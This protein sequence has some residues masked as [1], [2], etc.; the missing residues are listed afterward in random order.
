MESFHINL[1]LKSSFIL[2]QYT[3]WLYKLHSLQNNLPLLTYVQKILKVLSRNII[4]HTKHLQ[5]YVT[6][7]LFDKIKMSLPASVIWLV[8]PMGQAFQRQRNKDKPHHA[9]W[10]LF[11][12]LLFLP[13]F[14]ITVMRS[15]Y[16]QYSCPHVPCYYN[17]TASSLARM[18]PL[19]FAT[20][21]PLWRS[22]TFICLKSYNIPKPAIWED[23]ITQVVNKLYT[24]RE[25]KS[26]HSD[27]I[28]KELYFTASSTSQQTWP[29]MKLL[30]TFFRQ[31]L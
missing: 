10:F 22:F 9:P 16:K 8:S 4:K 25:I 21:P 29:T 13:A 30:I 6:F 1:T 28:P 20:N 31:K 5:L 12:M 19:N 24:R 26:K 15:A 11:S 23:V 27:C 18:L 2:Q 7:G 17:Q 3:D 14:P